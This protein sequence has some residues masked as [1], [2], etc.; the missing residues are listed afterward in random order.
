MNALWKV[1]VLGLVVYAIQL[2][3]KLLSLTDAAYSLANRA[4]FPSVN[5]GRSS[6][7]DTVWG[8][9]DISTLRTLMYLVIG[10]AVIT[11]GRDMFMTIRREAPQGVGPV[12]GGPPPGAPPA[13]P[14][15]SPPPPA[16][17]AAP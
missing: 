11:V 16:P 13:A 5:D 15:A 6:L 9:E 17:P 14:P 4:A 12:P 1:L 7:H 2:H 10:L 8:S 3:R